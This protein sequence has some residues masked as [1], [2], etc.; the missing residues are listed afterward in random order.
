VRSATERGW[1]RRSGEWV[2]VLVLGLPPPHRTP[3]YVAFPRLHRHLPIQIAPAPDH[4][5]ALNNGMGDDNRTVHRRERQRPRQRRRELCAPPTP[6]PSAPSAPSAASPASAASA[7]RR[8]GTVATAHGGTDGSEVC[9]VDI[10]DLTPAS[11]ESLR[12]NRGVRPRHGC[13]G[14]RTVTAIL[15]P[16]VHVA[17]LPPHHHLPL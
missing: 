9:T 3:L 1:L 12:I 8:R 5:R 7:A 4:R 15:H 13:N 16:L 11:T 2:L 14:R 17:G 10:N 6:A